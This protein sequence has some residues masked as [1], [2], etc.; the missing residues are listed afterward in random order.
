MQ[1]NVYKPTKKMKILAGISIPITAIAMIFFLVSVATY[2][3]NEALVITSMIIFL[4]AV[5]FEA[6][7]AIYWIRIW[8]SRYKEKYKGL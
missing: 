2:K 8:Y 7:V 5:F 6:F 4:L 3:S 1:D